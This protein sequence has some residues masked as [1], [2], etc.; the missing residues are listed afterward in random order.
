MKHEWEKKVIIYVKIKLNGWRN[1]LQVSLL[2]YCC[3]NKSKKTVKEK[4][5]KKYS[6]MIWIDWKM[7]SGTC[8]LKKKK[9]DI[10]DNLLKMG[11]I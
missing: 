4:K 3:W 9:L 6:R 10:L 7:S 5:E 2:K 1:L 11:F 8:S